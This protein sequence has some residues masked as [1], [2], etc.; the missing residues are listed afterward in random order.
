MRKPY[1]HLAARTRLSNHTECISIDT[2]IASDQPPQK[3][4]QHF[5]KMRLM[6]PNRPEQW[7]LLTPLE[8]TSCEFIILWEGASLYVY[9]THYRYSRE[10]R[11]LDRFL[12][13]N[14]GGDGPRTRLD[15]VSKRVWLS[16]TFVNRCSTG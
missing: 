15:S 2:Q 5:R 4:P 8:Q 9:W 14:R 12:V 13:V 16:P 11:T 7:M 1:V 6:Y 10:Q 3:R